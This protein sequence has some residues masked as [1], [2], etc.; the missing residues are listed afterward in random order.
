MLA[1]RILGLGAR[2]LLALSLVCFLLGGYLLY[3]GLA[4][5]RTSL[6]TEGTVV[7]YREVRDGDAQ[8]WRPR[9]KFT[10]PSGDIIT[11]EGQLATTTQRFTVGAAVP[12]IFSPGKPGEARLATFADNWLGPLASGIIGFLAF[13]AGIFIRRAAKRSLPGRA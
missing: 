2:L 5:D 6:T 13:G 9:V 8:R 4:F 11:F 3:R 1:L 7:S 12:V 10:T